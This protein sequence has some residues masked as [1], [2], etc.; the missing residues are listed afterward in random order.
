MCRV[1]GMRAIFSSRLFPTDLFSDCRE[2]YAPNR[3]SLRRRVENRCPELGSTP[4]FKGLELQ[5]E[6][7]AWVYSF[8]FLEFSLEKELRCSRKQNTDCVV[9]PWNFGDR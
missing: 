5:Y 7:L 9:I 3:E 6:N 8:F 2:V 1:P 4:L